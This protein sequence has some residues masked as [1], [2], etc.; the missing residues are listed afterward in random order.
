MPKCINIVP[1]WRCSRQTSGRPMIRNGISLSSDGVAKTT[2]Q[3]S[4][5]IDDTWTSAM[6]T[7]LVQICNRRQ[8]AYLLATILNQRPSCAVE[9]S[10]IIGNRTYRS[11][12]V[13]CA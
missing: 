3:C 1:D 9:H 2:D 6:H 10:N 13:T 5:E 11:N 4:V 8:I 7:R 12:N